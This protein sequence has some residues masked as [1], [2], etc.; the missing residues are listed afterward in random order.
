MNEQIYEQYLNILYRD[1]IANFNP[2]TIA[3]TSGEILYGSI[4]K[5][6]PH[7]NL[8]EQDV[9]A[10]L[11]SAKGKIVSQIFLTTPVKSA[12]GVE[13]VPELHQIAASVS[14]RIQNDLP[15]LYENQREMTFICGDFLKIPLERVTVA[16]V[17]ATCFP[18]SLVDELGAVI[19]NTSSIRSVFS[20]RPL[21]KLQR[22]AFR[23]VIPIECSW[24]STLGYFYTR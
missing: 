15:H 24:D 23:K 21:A 10:D 16:V 12:I 1:T 19:D 3:E 4:N 7:L 20:L 2:S 13:I 22:L 5:L 18:P 9:F 11:G 6:I 8:N 14:E 17:N